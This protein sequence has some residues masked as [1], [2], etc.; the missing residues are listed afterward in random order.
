MTPKMI[1]FD[2]DGTLI[3]EGDTVI[4]Q[5]TKNA[6]AKARANGH[7]TFINTG[8]TFFNIDPFILDLGF[9]GLSAAAELIFII[10]G[11]SFSHIQFLMT[12]V[13]K[14]FI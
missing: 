5:S 2:I 10:T 11:K 14:Q 6:I 12:A 7:L 4:S 13:W 8:R 3:P 9:D 1:F